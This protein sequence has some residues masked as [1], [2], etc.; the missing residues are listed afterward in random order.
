MY[1]NKLSTIFALNSD[2]HFKERKRKANLLDL[3]IYFPFP[4]FFI[5]S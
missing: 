4:L 5:V 3:S 1:D 2:M